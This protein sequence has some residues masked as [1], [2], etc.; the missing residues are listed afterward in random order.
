MRSS[1]LLFALFLAAGIPSPAT[2]QIN[3]PNARA[4]GLVLED[5]TNVPI[6][7]ARVVFAFRGRSRLPTT[8]DKDGRYSFDELEPGRI[9]SLWR[10]RDTFLSIPRAFPP[11]GL[12]RDK[13]STWRRFP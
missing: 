2:P 12:L 10:K 4:S 6:A 13:R 7:G 11:S 8:T 5:G 9:V 1:G 3:G